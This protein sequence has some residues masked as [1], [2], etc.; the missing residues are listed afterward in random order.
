MVNYA[1]ENDLNRNNGGTRFRDRVA[2]TALAFSM[3]A[4]TASAMVDDPSYTSNQ[5]T[6]L[7][8]HMD[9]GP[10]DPAMHGDAA[11]TNADSPSVALQSSNHNDDGYDYTGIGS[12]AFVPTP[13]FTGP[14][15][16]SLDNLAMSDREFNV[17]EQL[18]AHIADVSAR[19]FVRVTETAV[20][21]FHDPEDESKEYYLTLKVPLG[22]H[23]ALKYWD[24]VGQSI[25]QLADRLTEYDREILTA[26]V[27]VGVEWDV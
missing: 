8:R 26:R 27:G 17:L 18:L 11:T 1:D 3:F 2:L 22:T 4:P 19:Q 15:P 9:S 10:F 5:D 21:V 12:L 23:E 20:D 6:R 7:E 16:G 13:V 14:P 25:E 24:E